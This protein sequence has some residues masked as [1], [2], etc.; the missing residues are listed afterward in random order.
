M[1]TEGC[2][3]FLYRLINSGYG[4]YSERINYRM[5]VGGDMADKKSNKRMFNVLVVG[6]WLVDEDWVGGEFRSF[7]SS[8]PGEKHLRG[9][10]TSVDAVESISGAGLTASTIHRAIRNAAEIKKT[11]FA[12]VGVGA[13]H[14]YDTAI[15]QGMVHSGE[16]NYIPPVNKT[17]EKYGPRSRYKLKRNDIQGSN[18]TLINL[19]DHDLTSIGNYPGTNR[20]IRVYQHKGRKVE[21]ALR[22][23][24]EAKLPPSGYWID[25]SLNNISDTIKTVFNK[26]ENGSINCEIDAVVIKDLGKGV[27]SPFLVEKLADEFGDKKWYVTTKRWTLPP[28]NDLDPSEY[29]PATIKGLLNNTPNDWM[30]H[31]SKVNLRCL[32]IPQVAA[33]TAVRD[34]ALTRWINFKGEP[35]HG[36]IRQWIALR[37]LFNSNSNNNPLIVVL[38]QNQR[39]L[40][41][42]GGVAFNPFAMSGKIYQQNEPY[43]F[44]D[45]RGIETQFTSVLQGAFVAYDLYCSDITTESG[46]ANLFS[47]LKDAFDFTVK[48]MRGEVKR[49]AD[50]ETWGKNDDIRIIFEP[51]EPDKS[52][53][54]QDEKDIKDTWCE[55]QASLDLEAFAADLIRPKDDINSDLVCRDSNPTLDAGAKNSTR[56]SI[57]LNHGMTDVDGYICMVPSKRRQLRQL[58]LQLDDFKRGRRDRARS[59][60]LLASPGSGKTYL[61]VRLAASADYPS[62]L[63]FNI[64]QM[65]SREGLLGCFDMISTTQAKWPNQPLIVFIDEVNAK[66]EGHPVWDMFLAPLEEGSYVRADKQFHIM[67][68]FWIF[69]STKMPGVD[70]NNGGETKAEENND[71]W[72][73][74]NSRLTMPVITLAR[75]NIKDYLDIN[76]DLE[77]KAFDM[78]NKEFR[79]ARLEGVYAGAV[80]TIQAFPDVRFISKSILSI[81]AHLGP[82]ISIRQ[83]GYFVRLFKEIK[84]GEVAGKNLKS[85]ALEW[86]LRWQED[87]IKELNINGKTKS[88][89]ILNYDGVVFRNDNIVPQQHKQLISEIEEYRPIKLYELQQLL[90]SPSNHELVKIIW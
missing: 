18:V 52:I 7:T 19:V 66:L 60:L 16:G 42:D 25:D 86:L 83:L 15:L 47:L 78:L 56:I 3:G 63:M 24:W 29:H 9:L 30:R 67:P 68:C 82:W 90:A 6:D 81:F 45:P 44:R 49:I 8:R 80:L 48:R 75:E 34:N 69:A 1:S 21:L 57:N 62:P 39:V 20:I 26:I 13:W 33:D 31:L 84:R 77:Q 51:A 73:D 64:T 12:I 74:F 61:I 27:V 37:T 10:A 22:Y 59:C 58:L 41:F 14:Q 55:W 88:R 76:G 85:E 87:L 28:L 4:M 65:Y 89:G 72:S 5:C 2:T 70:N 23:D 38:P 40:A 54:W 71:K 53:T 50:P 46:G 36:A 35:T 11:V 43:A 79:L 32:F 17:R